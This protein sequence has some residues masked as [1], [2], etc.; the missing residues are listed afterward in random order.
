MN[1]KQKGIFEYLG[2][3]GMISMLG[4]ATGWI[5]VVLLLQELPFLAISAAIIAFF[6]DCLDGYVAR[7]IHKESEFGRQL[8]GYFDFF[9]YLVF[10]AL[11]FCK[12]ISPNLLGMSVGFLV[13]ATGTFRLVRFNVEGFVVKNNQLYYAGI[14]VCHVSLTAII[15]FFTQQFYPQAVSI[16]A[17]PVMVIISLL[18]VSRIPVKKTSMYGFWLIIALILLIVSLGFQLWHK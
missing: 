3:P 6:L 17:V 15:L 1:T 8:D 7:K 18:Q 4:L 12:Y 9:N 5:A 16:I 14:V 10:S 11:L 13:L 2:I